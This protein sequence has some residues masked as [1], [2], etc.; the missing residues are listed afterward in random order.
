MTTEQ[1][2]ADACR[3]TGLK[4][5]MSIEAGHRSKEIDPGDLLETLYAIADQLDPPLAEKAAPQLSLLE[6]AK[7][8]LE[9][10]EDQMVTHVEWDRLQA[11]V[12][13]ERTR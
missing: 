9:A 6:A 3:T 7:A 13:A 5:E 2:I 1:R 11:A 10:R 4:L 12:D 8:L